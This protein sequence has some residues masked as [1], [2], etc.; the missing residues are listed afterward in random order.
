MLT[1]EEAVARLTSIPARAH[2]LTDRG[3]LATGH[4]GR[5]PADRPRPPGHARLAALRARLPAELGRYVVDATGY[6]AVIV[7]GAVL[8]R[9][10]EWTGA[11][12]GQ[13]L[14][15]TPRVP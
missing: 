9:D 2:G 8:L 14:R 12:P 7:N 6:H 3:V 5:R 4:G 11:R 13:I 10:G 15:G 1:L